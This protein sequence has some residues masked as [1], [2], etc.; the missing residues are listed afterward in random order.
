MHFERA[1]TNYI[2]NFTTNTP[3]PPAPCHPPQ[4][5]PAKCCLDDVGMLN[6]SAIHL[7]ACLVSKALQ[8]SDVLNSIS[9]KS[10]ERRH[11]SAPLVRCNRDINLTLQGPAA[12]SDYSRFLSSFRVVTHIQVLTSQLLALFIAGPSFFWCD[13]Y[14]ACVGGQNVLRDSLV[15]CVIY[16]TLSRG[17]GL[18]MAG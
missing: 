1:L 7:P 14:I 4:A 15:N 13:H 5:P 16:P 18:D 12:S 3:L 10:R 8:H 9:L 17:R 2:A 11:R 6:L